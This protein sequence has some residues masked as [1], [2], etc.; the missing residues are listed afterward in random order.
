[1][2][3][4][5]KQGQRERIARWVREGRDAERSRKERNHVLIHLGIAAMRMVKSGERELVD[6]LRHIDDTGKHGLVRKVVEEE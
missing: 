5:D 1:M 4:L 6:F 3:S 2:A